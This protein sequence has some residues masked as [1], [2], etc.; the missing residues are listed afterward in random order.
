MAPTE[1]MFAR[2]I[3]S[4]FNRLRPTEKKMVERKNINGK[5]YNPS[6]KYIFEE[7]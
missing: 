2:K 7:L 3:H 5:I 1:F 6:K 4:V